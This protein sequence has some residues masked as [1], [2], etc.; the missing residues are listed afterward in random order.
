L[1]PLVE[2]A[3]KYAVARQVAGG[4]LR[5]GARR[6]GPQ[7]VLTVADDGPGCGSLEGG[8]APAGKGVGLRNT[9]ERLSVLYGDAGSLSIRNLEPGIEVTLRLPFE[10]SQT[11]R[12]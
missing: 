8:R 6:E 5:I 4:V 11:I 2:N 7:L 3:I 9:R 10:T 1:Q 12:D